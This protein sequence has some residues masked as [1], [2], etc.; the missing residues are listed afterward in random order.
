MLEIFLLIYRFWK[1]FVIREKRFSKFGSSLKTSTKNVKLHGSFFAHFFAKLCASK[2]F[3]IAILFLL[4]WYKWLRLSM[5]MWYDVCIPVAELLMGKTVGSS[6]PEHPAITFWW[7]LFWWDAP[8]QMHHHYKALL[9]KNS[10]P[11]RFHAR[12]V[13]QLQLCLVL[14]SCATLGL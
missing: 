4:A 2:M 7:E 5:Y 13:W 10:P 11:S 8:S 14:Y 9:R 1:P 3:E 12:L 6:D